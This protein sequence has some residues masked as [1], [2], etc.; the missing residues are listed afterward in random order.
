MAT[1]R[2]V[3]RSSQG[4]KYFKWWDSN[5]ELWEDDDGFIRNYHYIG[6]ADKLEDAITMA[7]VHTGGSDQKVEIKDA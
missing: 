4:N 7:K 5:N 2:I 6:K 1:K 3:V